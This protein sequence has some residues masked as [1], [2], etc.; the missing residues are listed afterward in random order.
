MTDEHKQFHAVVSGRVQGVN[1][2]YYTTLTAHELGV[3]GWVR[4]LPNGDVE[5]VAEGTQAQLNQMVAF[6]HKGP[7]AAYVTAVEIEW[8]KAS[9]VFDSFEV[10]YFHA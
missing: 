6:L 5:V 7:P 9:H 8:R 3:T 2:R 10:R 1:F 4:N